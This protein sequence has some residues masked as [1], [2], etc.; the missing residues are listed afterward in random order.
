MIVYRLEH[1]QTHNGPFCD[2]FNLKITKKQREILNDLYEWASENKNTPGIYSDIPECKTT[3][4]YNVREYVCGTISMD[5]LYHWFSQW[6]DDLL[7]MQFEIKTFEVPDDKVFIG[8]YQCI[9]HKDYAK[10]VQ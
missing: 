3:L 4:N 1:K 6:L 9:F 10:E 8:K 5:Q 7:K 2:T